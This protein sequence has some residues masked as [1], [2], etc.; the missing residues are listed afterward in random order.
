MP[1]ENKAVIDEFMNITGS[2]KTVAESFLRSS[3]FSLTQGLNAYFSEPAG[4]R[5]SPNQAMKSVTVSAKDLVAFFSSYA[6][7]TTGRIESDGVERLGNDLGIE[8]LDVA[9]LVIACRC[10]AKHMGSFE[11]DE[12]VRGM[13]TLG[14]ANIGALKKALPSIHERLSVSAEEFKEVYLFAFQF[15]LEPGAR[16]ISLEMATALWEILLPTSGWKLADQWVDFIRSDAVVLN[17]KAVTRDIWNILLTLARDVP[18]T[19]SLEAF[20]RDGGA[21]PLI[22]DDFFD[23]LMAYMQK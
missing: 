13:K 19:D 23:H 2:S 15:S 6:D 22:I 5:S 1:A 10:G 7:S 17:G 4:S 9:W 18:D 12:W 16:N 20:D 8:T 14:C 3:G 21:W 11:Q